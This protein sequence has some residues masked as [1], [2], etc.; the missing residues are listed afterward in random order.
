MK[1]KLGEW[2]DLS[3]RTQHLSDFVSART[4]DVLVKTKN[5]YNFKVKRAVG[6]TGKKEESNMSFNEK[7]SQAHQSSTPAKKVNEKVI[8]WSNKVKSVLK[9][10]DGA[11][12]LKQIM[13]RKWMR[14]SLFGVGAL[15][16][17][18]FVEKTMS[19]DPEPAI[20]KYYEKGYDTIK[21]NMTD[22]GSPVDLLK[23]ASKVIVKHPSTVRNGTITSVRSK[24]ERNAALFLNKHAIRHNRY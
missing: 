20:P 7:R 5:F 17:L 2:L 13:E 14:R 18:S 21:E 10:K 11:Q 22:F 12:L 4:R 15:L 24:T 3:K 1:N 9:G 16:A 6:F 8:P 19:F 23:T